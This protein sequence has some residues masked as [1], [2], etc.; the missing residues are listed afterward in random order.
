MG[1]CNS[2]KKVEK[3]KRTIENT[4]QYNSTLDVD[5]K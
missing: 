5:D 2:I 1:N 4:T 3:P